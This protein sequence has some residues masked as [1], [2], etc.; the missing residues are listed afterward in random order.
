MEKGPNLPLTVQVAL[1]VLQI[2][3]ISHK[4]YHGCENF[5]QVLFSPLFQ[6]FHKVE[7]YQPPKMAL[8]IKLKMLLIFYILF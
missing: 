6:Q 2:V 1:K 5:G 4:A 7:F 3:H 8:K